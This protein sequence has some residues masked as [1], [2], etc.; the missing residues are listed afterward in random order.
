MLRKYVNDAHIGR[1]AFDP[2][3]L[4]MGVIETAWTRNN[5]DWQNDIKHRPIFLSH[6][7]TPL[8]SDNF[9]ENYWNP[10][11]KAAGLKAHPHQ[12]RHWFVTNAVRNIEQTCKTETE[13]R[14]EKQKLIEYMA[15]RSGEQTLKCYEHV[16][17]SESFAPRIRAIHRALTRLEKAW[18]RTRGSQEFKTV[19]G[20]QDGELDEDLKFILGGE[21]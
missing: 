1:A 10:A 19:P 3:Q 18:P 17:R 11:I 15:W 12:G 8:T 16:L 5:A 21:S 7:G 20:A 9:R 2:A 4:R 6:R 14:T 13:A